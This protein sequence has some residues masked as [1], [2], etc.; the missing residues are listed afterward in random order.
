[1]AEDVIPVGGESSL[2]PG[3]GSI[4]A[5]QAKPVG[6][7]VSRTE[8]ARQTAYRFRFVLV[9][10]ALAIVAGSAVGALVVV[11]D[12]PRT[13][14][15]PPWATGFVP[16]GNLNARL[17]QIAEV[18]PKGYR[19]VNGKQL[20]GAVVTAPQQQI[21]P[22][23]QSFVTLPVA[24]VEVHDRGN[25]TVADASSSIQFVLCGDGATCEITKGTPSQKRYYLL[26]REALEMSLYALK[27]V[28][29]LDS[30][31]VLL[32]P[33]TTRG[34]S[35]SGERR[36]TALFLRRADVK[37]ELSRPLATI[38]AAKPPKIGRMSSRDLATL[39][40]VAFPHTFDWTVA[41]AQD[42]AFVRMLQPAGN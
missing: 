25:I 4:E 30:V 38:L 3:T 29:D 7:P 16:N 2:E 5:E 23:G 1:V 11:L 21:S 35:N 19:N 28:S 34:G 17:F 36:Q 14:A 10:F 6:P 20:V 37:R 26:E 27:Y 13:H 33:S 39:R 24:R 9:Y 42:G 31:T 22:D 18:V 40:S 32:P 41:Q 15:P 12:R 8:R